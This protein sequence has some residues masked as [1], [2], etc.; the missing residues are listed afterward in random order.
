MPKPLPYPPGHRLR[1]GLRAA[2]RARDA[3]SVVVNFRSDTSGHRLQS[4]RII[5]KNVPLPAEQTDQLRRLMEMA[6][7]ASLPGRHR[8]QGRPSTLTWRLE[9]D[10]ME[11]A[12]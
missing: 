2:L 4:Y 8:Q 7:D 1:E 6:I 5:P 3:D 12:Y 10:R 11:I 9:E